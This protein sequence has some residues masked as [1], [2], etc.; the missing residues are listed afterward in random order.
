MAD[1]K[2]FKIAAVSHL[3]E[4]DGAE[5]LQHWFHILHNLVKSVFFIVK[6]QQEVD[7]TVFGETSCVKRMILLA[8]SMALV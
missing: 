7:S 2:S 1:Q 4:I 5:V 8:I 3:S 6:G